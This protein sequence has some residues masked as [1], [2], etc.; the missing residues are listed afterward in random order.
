[1]ADLSPEDRA[2]LQAAAT[3][4][5][6]ALAPISGYQVGAAVRLHDGTI[7]PGCNVENW[8]LPVSICA[9]HG[10]IAAATARGTHRFDVVAVFTPSSPPAVPC[11]NCRQILHNHGIKRVLLGNPEGE[12]RQLTLNELLP[13]PF[14]Y[15]RDAPS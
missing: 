9:E 5:L 10:A 14:D 4:R 13:F 1:V 8:V 3:A 11:G 6:N 7:V 2:L 12:V 15:E